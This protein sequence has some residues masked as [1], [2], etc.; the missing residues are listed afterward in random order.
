M[1]PKSRSFDSKIT[2]GIVEDCHLLRDGIELFLK[3]SGIFNVVF[4]KEDCNNLVESLI[5]FGPDI[6]LLNVKMIRTNGIIELAKSFNLLPNQKVILLKM[7]DEELYNE[8]LDFFAIDIVLTKNVSFDVLKEKIIRLH[9]SEIKNKKR[10][11]FSDFLKLRS[12]SQISISPKELEVLKLLENNYSDSEIAEKL[13]IK[14]RT[15]EKHRSNILQKT[16]S[17]NL[18]AVVRKLERVSFNN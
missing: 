2:I 12:D 9:G 8:E 13:R 5:D 3:Q 17:K 4:K 6:V 11:S 15:V 14:K 7:F 1:K 18:A 10:F 16:N